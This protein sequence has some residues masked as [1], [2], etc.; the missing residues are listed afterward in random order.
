MQIEKEVN[1][2]TW[3]LEP[4]EYNTIPLIILEHCNIF[5][6]EDEEIKYQISSKDFINKVKPF[7]RII[8]R[9]TV[10][11][12]ILFNFN[13]LFITKFKVDNIGDRYISGYCSDIKQ[14]II[15]DKYKDRIVSIQQPYHIVVSSDRIVTVFMEEA[16]DN[17]IGYNLIQITE[18]EFWINVKSNDIVYIHYS[19]IKN[20]SK[21]YK[22]FTISEDT[23]KMYKLNILDE[24]N[25]ELCSI[26]ESIRYHNERTGDDY[27]E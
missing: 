12:G 18:K 9:N 24:Y 17:H 5:V 15:I 25:S 8:I 2:K 23:D 27:D 6:G 7:D 20:L 16:A 3:I 11:K 1:I 22:V 26:M 10:R 21:K 19:Y 13:K 14:L 4:Y